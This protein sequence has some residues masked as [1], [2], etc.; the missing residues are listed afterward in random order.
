MLVNDYL[1]IIKNR[2]ILI[3]MSKF[4]YFVFSNF[5]KDIS[6]LLV[7]NFVCNLF[8]GM[9]IDKEDRFIVEI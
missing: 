5:V 3:C 6:L 9:L 2:I 4:C 8:L 7:I 1:C